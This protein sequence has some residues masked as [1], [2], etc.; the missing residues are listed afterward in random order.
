M[1]FWWFSS[2]NVAAVTVTRWPCHITDDSAFSPRSDE[3][4]TIQIHHHATPWIHL[5]E[6]AAM[7]SSVTK[8]ITKSISLCMQK[9]ESNSTQVPATAQYKSSL[10]IVDVLVVVATHCKE[11]IF[12]E[13]RTSLFVEIGP[14][15]MA[16][17]HGHPFSSGGLAVGRIG[18]T[19]I[20]ESCI[21]FSSSSP[22]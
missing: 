3:E 20:L 21:S 11:E 8:R 12:P 10:V 18:L 7:S 14:W 6:S 5:R 1:Y 19:I 4:R 15:N 16:N 13:E 17:R 9:L 2:T 22:Y